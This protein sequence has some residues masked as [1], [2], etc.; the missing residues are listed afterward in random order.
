MVAGCRRTA[1]G[2]ARGP[3][4]GNRSHLTQRAPL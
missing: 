2:L 3:G 1:A 4:S